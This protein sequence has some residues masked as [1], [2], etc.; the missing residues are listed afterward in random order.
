[1]AEFPGCAILMDSHLR[2]YKKFVEL[3][4]RYGYQTQDLP[5]FRL[6]PGQGHIR[7]WT[8]PED[9]MHPGRVVV[10]QYAQLLLNYVCGLNRGN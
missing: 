4:Q 3:E 9:F 1:M 10:R 6:Y 5:Q 8:G 2:V 7:E